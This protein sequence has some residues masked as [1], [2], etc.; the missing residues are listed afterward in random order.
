MFFTLAKILSLFLSPLVISIFVLVISALLFKKKPVLSRAL[1]TSAILL[2]WICSTEW[3]SSWIISP[4]ESSTARNPRLQ[5]IDAVVVL[6]GMTDLKLS[7]NGTLELAEGVDRILQGI[8]LLQRF[9]QSRLII[10]GGTGDPFRQET[11]EAKLL[12]KHFVLELGIP[13][14]RILLDPGSR[15]TYENAVNSVKIMSDHGLQN[16]VLVT[17][18]SHMPRALA[19]FQ[20]LG[21]DPIPY[22]VDFRSH[23]GRLDF[24][25]I[26][27]DS[28]SL[29]RTNNA[30]HE[31][32]GT[33]V[34]R[35]QG[36]L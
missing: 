17:S 8:F 1:L 10:S 36:H 19:C 14:K 13:M 31:Y 26:L 30:L 29:G 24:R 28:G 35:A 6:A 5:K 2:L 16:P 18:A 25:S 9:P 11:S 33:L 32:L 22:P 23:A 7:G 20:K 4:L 21:I 34:Y 15:N 27:P 12:S 3:F